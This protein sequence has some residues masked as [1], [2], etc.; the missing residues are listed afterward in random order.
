M[1]MFFKCDLKKISL[2]FFDKNCVIKSK[3]LIKKRFMFFLFMNLFSES[4]IQLVFDE[5]YVDKLF[6][7]TGFFISNPCQFQALLF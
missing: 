7:F 4:L 1:L 6:L 3:F 5:N 2:C